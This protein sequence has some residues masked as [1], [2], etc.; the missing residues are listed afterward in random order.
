[1][2]YQQYI[3]YIVICFI[4]GKN[5]SIRWKRP[6]CHKNWTNVIT[7]IVLEWNQSRLEGK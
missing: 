6:T 2:Y 5:R 7:C 1:V 4:G 3:C